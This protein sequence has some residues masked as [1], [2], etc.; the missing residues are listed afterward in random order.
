MSEKE[1]E[2]EKIQYIC[3]SCSDEGFFFHSIRLP[4]TKR[5]VKWIKAT[6][7]CVVFVVIKKVSKELSGKLASPNHSM[8]WQII[9]FIRNLVFTRV[10]TIVRS[11]SIVGE[12]SLLPHAK[13]LPYDIFP[14]HLYSLQQLMH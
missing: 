9:F 2:I 6:K 3:N 11:G 8:P 1:S 5:R 7:I 14:S 12:R 10:I 13:N 4:R